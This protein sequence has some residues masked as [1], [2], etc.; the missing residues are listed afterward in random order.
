[1]A[2]G[3]DAVQLCAIDRPSADPGIQ[4]VPRE[5]LLAMAAAIREALPRS[6]V[7]IY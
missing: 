6:A 2:A 1:V 7:D 4:N 5:R 3:P